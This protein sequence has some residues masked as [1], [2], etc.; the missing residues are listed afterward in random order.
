MVEQDYNR[1]IPV[2]LLETGVFC[3]KIKEKYFYNNL[4]KE[5][6]NGGV[7]IRSLQHGVRENGEHC[8]AAVFF[9]GLLQDGIRR[10]VT[11][12]LKYDCLMYERVFHILKNK[13][14]IGL[15]PAGSSLPSRINLQREF[16]T[17]EKTIRHAL[18]MLEEEGL[19]QTHQR[20]RPVVSP[21][22]DWRHQVTRLAVK[23]NKCR[24]H[25]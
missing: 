8:Y 6:R 24:D 12:M 2:Y 5:P 7:F 18:A 16:N 1:I 25:Q 20:K 13:I 4:D 23:K 3:C 11:I 22:Q 17:S 15:L 19:I 14:E 21:N 9:A 10:K